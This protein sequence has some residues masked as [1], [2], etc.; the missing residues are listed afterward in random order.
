ML[1]GEFLERRAGG[2]AAAGAGGDAG[3]EGAQAERLQQFAGGV[4]FLAAIAAGARRE[5]DAD[6]VADAFGRAERPSPPRTR[7]GP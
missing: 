3:R 5:R 7:P 6:G 2:A 4:D 1:L